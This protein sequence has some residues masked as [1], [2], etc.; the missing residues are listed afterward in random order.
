MRTTPTPKHMGLKQ[1]VKLKLLTP[2]QALRELP[3]GAEHT[4]TARWLR[5]QL[6][7][8]RQWVRAA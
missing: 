8:G 6:R 7:P 1:R 3:E 5:R 2:E 4:Y